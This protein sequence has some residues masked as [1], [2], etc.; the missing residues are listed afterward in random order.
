MPE[1]PVCGSMVRDDVP[2]VDVEHDGETYYFESTKCKERFVENPN[3]Y[4]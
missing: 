1:C 3:E 2:S 4:A